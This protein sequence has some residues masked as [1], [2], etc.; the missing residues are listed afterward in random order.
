MLFC[1]RYVDREFHK[2][3][4][5]QRGFYALDIICSTI[6][7]FC[8]IILEIL[9]FQNDSM[10]PVVKNLFFLFICLIEACF[11]ANIRKNIFTNFKKVQSLLNNAY[12]ITKNEFVGKMCQIQGRAITSM[13]FYMN[14][15]YTVNI[16]S[17]R[18]IFF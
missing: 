13:S 16:I 3:E 15:P 18:V 7:A 14:L 17:K 12:L 11:H 5:T 6:L 1:I 10:F 2:H 4:Y 9:I 8:C